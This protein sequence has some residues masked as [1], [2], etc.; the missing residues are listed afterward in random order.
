MEKIN[1]LKLPITLEECTDMLSSF[2]KAFSEEDINFLENL[3]D[4]YIN[5]L[6][7][8]GAFLN[9]LS[10]IIDTYNKCE[11]RGFNLRELKEKGF[12]K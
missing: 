1:L 5:I 12:I 9:S 7:K 6:N 8:W 11:N 10:F 3:N 4:D 2:R